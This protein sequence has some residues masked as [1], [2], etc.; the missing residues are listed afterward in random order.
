MSYLNGGQTNG[1]AGSNYSGG[2]N[3]GPAA[4][5]PRIR[6]A[7]FLSQILRGTAVIAG[8]FYAFFYRDWQP[9]SLQANICYA[10]L[11]YLLIE[12][13]VVKVTEWAALVRAAR[14]QPEQWDGKTERRWRRHCP[15]CT[16]S[17]Y[18]ES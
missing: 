8:V 7:I 11:A 5:S 1:T 14:G 12:Q 6:A 4:F 17:I 16:K 2:G 13:G 18:S 10:F 9:T 3:G 15:H